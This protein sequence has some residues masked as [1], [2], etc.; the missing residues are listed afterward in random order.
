VTEPSHDTGTES[1]R[2]TAELDRRLFELESLL[3][4]G[5]VLQGVLDVGELCQLVLS[6]IR[7]R[8]LVS[9]LAVFLL[10]EE[11]QTFRLEACTTE[12]I[13]DDLAFPADRGILWSRLRAGQP[14]SVVDLEGA[15]RFPDFFASHELGQLGSDLWL[16]L[17]MAERIV[18]VV[19]VGQCEGGRELSERELNFLGRLVKTAAVSLN[20]AL[21]Y[22]RIEAA[23]GQ[24]KGSL[25]K[26][27]LLFDITRALSAVSDLTQLLRI[28]LDRSLEA[29]GAERGSMMLLDEAS[30]DLVIKVVYGLPDA[31]TERK[32]NEGLIECQRFARGEGIAGRVL[33]SGLAIRVDD[34][35]KDRSFERGTSAHV[36][37]L[38]CVPLNVDDETIGVINISNKSG[39]SPFSDED[40][41]ILS[42]LADQAAVAIARARLYEAAITDGLTGLHV[43]RFTLHRLGQ[44][45]KRSRR[46][47]PGLSVIMGDIDHFKDINDTWG[48]PAGDRVLEVVSERLRAALRQDV[49]IAGRYG[50]EEF[51]IVVP[52]T[53]IEGARDCAERLRSAVEGASIDAETEAPLRVTMSF[54]VAQLS[55][56][57]SGKDLIARADAALYEAKEAG[58]NQVAIAEPPVGNS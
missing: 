12:G 11:A 36:R 45:V 40:E 51:L 33:D 22:R 46:Y 14:F 55:P 50:G 57:E 18:G 54:G 2:H 9:D 17:V 25:H 23:R 44:E 8:T 20:T 24:L 19:S 7:E 29:A 35:D 10:D 52:Q 4:A 56:G 31:E 15:H 30:G 34:T 48:H 5:E 32:I 26:L 37:S 21:L 13:T 41:E 28:I 43:R 27:S 47:G 6:M 3:K 53:G 1:L 42:A 58:R 38:I 16:P 39:G 49:D